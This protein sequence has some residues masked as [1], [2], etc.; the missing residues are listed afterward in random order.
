MLD[1][2]VFCC[3][4]LRL[5]CWVRRVY[6]CVLCCVKCEVCVLNEVAFVLGLLEC[7]RGVL[8]FISDDAKMKYANMICAV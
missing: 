2:G 3:F 8:F 6:Q 5:W 7:V 1:P 4:A